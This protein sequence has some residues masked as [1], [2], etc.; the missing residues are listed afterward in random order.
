MQLSKIHAL[1][2]SDEELRVLLWRA[3]QLA[4]AG[5]D[6]GVALDLSLTKDLDLHVAASLLARG[7]PQAT[8][9]RILL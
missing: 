2:R 4:G 9:V 5:Y 1:P 6:A 7:C 3:S 8:A